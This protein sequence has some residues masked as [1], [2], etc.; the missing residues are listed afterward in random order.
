[1]KLCFSISY[2]SYHL[3]K[4]IEKVGCAEFRDY[5]YDSLEEFKSGLRT[6]E[7]FKARNFC[8]YKD[9]TELIENNLIDHGDG[10]SWHLTYYVS[11]FGKK[12]LKNE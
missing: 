5:E 11:E 8:D 6:E 10:M 4:E 7:W 9:L 12:I 1:M 3:L 2:Q